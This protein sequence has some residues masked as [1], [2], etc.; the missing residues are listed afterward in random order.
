MSFA[1]RR[2]GVVPQALDMSLPA[3]AASASQLYLRPAASSSPRPSHRSRRRP[4]L[5]RLINNS[6]I[7]SWSPWLIY[8]SCS[9]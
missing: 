9:C 7:K 3:V 4:M 8:K 2:R 1:R 5:Q 6:Q